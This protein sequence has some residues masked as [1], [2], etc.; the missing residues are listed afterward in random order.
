MKQ[1]VGELLQTRRDLLKLGGYG[2]LGSF[3]SQALWPVEARAA[4]RTKVR[5]G[6]RFGI[7]I[8]LAGA[9]SHTDAFDFKE[10]PGTPKDLAVRPVNNGSIYLSERLF[11]EL[12]KEMHRIAVVRSL[13]SHEVVHFR[14]QYYTQAGRPLNPAIAP[15]IPSIGSVV[16]YELH[17]VQP[18]GGRMRRAIDGLPASEAFGA[19][20]ESEAGHG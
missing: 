12:S 1:T 6:A 15:E 19:R 4:A 3:A 10:G 18:R 16:S 20:C 13:K 9:I 5:G 17:R 11:P 2:L 7:V 8:E 14:G